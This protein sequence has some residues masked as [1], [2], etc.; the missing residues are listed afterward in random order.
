MK[1]VQQ[2]RNHQLVPITSLFLLM[3]SPKAAFKQFGGLIPHLGLASGSQFLC[4]PFLCDTDGK[5]PV[6]YS[7]CWSLQLGTAL[8]AVCNCTDCSVR[9][10]LPARVGWRIQLSHVLAEVKPSVQAR[11]TSGLTPNCTGETWYHQLP[12]PSLTQSLI[13]PNRLL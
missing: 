7:V 2:C 11:A 3:S 4:E 6:K 9:F 5:N 12:L 1:R 8:S 10:L 13:S